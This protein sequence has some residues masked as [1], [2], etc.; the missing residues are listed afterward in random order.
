MH[1]IFTHLIL[2]LVRYAGAAVGAL[3]SHLRPA[4]AGRRLQC[5]RPGSGAPLLGALH[6]D[7]H[8]GA[9]LGAPGRPRQPGALRRHAL[10]QLALHRQHERLPASSQR[11]SAP[12][13][14]EYLHAARRHHRP[15]DHQQILRPR[16]IVFPLRLNLQHLFKF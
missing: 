11:R 10:L 7:E 14:Q 5:V 9:V 8:G 12:L 1:V 13:L 4:D 3:R 15:A 16:Y 6:A 2:Y